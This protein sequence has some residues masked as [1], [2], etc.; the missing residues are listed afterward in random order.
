MYIILCRK[1][2]RARRWE[3]KT[4]RGFATRRAALAWVEK[5]KWDRRLTAVGR[6]VDIAM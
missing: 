3:A 4:I 5:W 2:T 1:T 6:V